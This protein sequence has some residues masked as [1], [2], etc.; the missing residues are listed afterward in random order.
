MLAP[1]KPKS[2]LGCPLTVEIEGIW[3]RKD[4]LVP[5][6][7]LVGG[8]DTLTGFDELYS[9]R[10]ISA[11]KVNTSKKK[12]IQVKYLVTKCDVNFGD[13]TK[14]HSRCSMKAAKFFNK[15]CCK[16]RICLKIIQLRGMF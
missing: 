13:T 14:S 12:R 10:Q 4:V 15:R 9:V 1:S 5:V 7:G 2:F 3:L 8:D 11:S 6:S 16:R